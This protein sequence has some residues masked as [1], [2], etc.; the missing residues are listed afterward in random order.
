MTIRKIINRAICRIASHDAYR[1][2]IHPH[3]R[4]CRPLALVEVE[5]CRRCGRELARLGL[6]PPNR[7]PMR[8]FQLRTFGAIDD[9]ASIRPEHRMA[10]GQALERHWSRTV[11]IVSPTK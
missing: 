10:I 5:M 3:D 4:N 11:R 8:Q 7:I 2:T 9:F 6:R 1:L